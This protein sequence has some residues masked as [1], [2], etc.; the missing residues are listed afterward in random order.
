MF[1]Y[2]EKISE[3]IS[4][5]FDK[6]GIDNFYGFTLLSLIIA[7]SYWRDFKDWK[8]VPNWKKGI[9]GSTTVGSVILVFFSLLRI[10]GL[11]KF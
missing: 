11:F 4:F 3:A 10:I 6:L 7:L 1:D 5:V 8:N 2:K 9:I